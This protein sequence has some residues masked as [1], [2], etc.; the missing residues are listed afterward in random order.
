MTPQQ[1]HTAALCLQAAETG[2]MSFPEI[3][4]TLIGAGFESYLIDFRRNAAT[5]YLP[6]GA[7][8]EFAFH[9]VETPIAPAF[10]AAEIKAAIRDAQTN[11]PGYTYKGFCERVAAAGC[12]GYLTSFSGRRVAYFGRTAD[13]HVEY[14]P[15]T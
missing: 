1:Q 9:K 14:F 7:H 4:A 12:A 15:K 5:Y 13:L 11:A 6:D 10:D 8:T 2:T 3:V